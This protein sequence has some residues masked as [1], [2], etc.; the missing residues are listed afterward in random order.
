MRKALLLAKSSNWIR[1]LI[2]YLQGGSD[3]QTTEGWHGGGG[4]RLYSALAL[5][6]LF[7]HRLHELVHQLVVLFPSDPFVLE[8]DIQ[9]V[10]QQR[11]ELEI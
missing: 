11:L 7:R 4:G 6:S 5:S 8:S 9:R 1:V 2:P 3:S 10:I